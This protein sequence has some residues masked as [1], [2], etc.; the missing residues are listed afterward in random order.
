MERE[1]AESRYD[2]LHEAMPYH[3]GTHQV[4][5]K[6][7]S[8]QRPYHFKSGVDIWVSTTD[9]NPDDDFLSAPTL[10]SF[11]EPSVEG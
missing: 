3:D 10:P 11:Q 4:W 5:S 8:A 7:R 2:A 6:E 1:A 9:L